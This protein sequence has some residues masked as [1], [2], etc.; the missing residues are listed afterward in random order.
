MTNLLSQP[1][2]RLALPAA[3]CGSLLIG[4]SEKPDPVTTTQ[5]QTTTEVAHKALTAADIKCDPDGGMQPY[6]GFKNPEDIVSI[7]GSDKLLISE[8]GEFMLDTPGTMVM[9]DTAKSEKQPIHVI[10]EN[11]G[12]SWGDASCPAPDVE[13][14]SPHGI[15]L[16]PGEN[17]KH[18]VLV[19]NHGGREA[20][21]FFQLAE[22]DN[23]WHLF[24]KGCA[25]P[26]EDPFINDVAG[27]KDGGFFVTHMWNK[28]T[29]FEKIVEQ[30]NNGENIGWV[31]EWQQDTGFVKVPNSDQLMP[32]GITVSADNSKIFV[33]IYLANK[34]IK[35]DRASGEID[36][37]FEV[38]QPDNI[39]IDSDGNLW[40]ASH[41]HDPIAQTC[42]EVEFGPCLLPFEIVKVNSE[43]LEKEVFLHYEGD[44][45]GYA[46]VATRVGD[47]L[48][49]GSAHGDRIVSVAVQ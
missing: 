34:T 12:D 15:D 45:M 10:W 4:C 42:T 14:F 33:N 44:A 43:T 2:R 46:T 16:V 41:K 40:V 3:I 20:V 1:L 22:Q 27:L 32:N 13:R 29:P 28:S 47:K 19:V 31:Y 30:F 8:M 11:E 6:C 24:W 18:K 36:G 49:L 48:Y 7:P 35:I 17:G 39:T 26:P 21:E 37:E 23:T 38:Q 9:F 25:I 5:E